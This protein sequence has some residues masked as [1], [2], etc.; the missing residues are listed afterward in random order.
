MGPGVTTVDV[1]LDGSTVEGFRP[2]AITDARADLVELLGDLL[3]EGRV[4]GLRV[5]M[6]PTPRVSIGAHRLGLRAIGGGGSQ[7][8]VA[9]FPIQIET[10]GATRAQLLLLDSLTA[11]VWDRCRKRWPSPCGPT[12]STPSSTDAVG[13]GTSYTRSQTISVDIPIGQLTLCPTDTE[14]CRHG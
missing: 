1:R 8:T 12:S 13:S 9:S 11:R 4:A 5:D 7:W 10:D 3:D 2:N 14:D 6:P